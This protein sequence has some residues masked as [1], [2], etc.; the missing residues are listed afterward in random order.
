GELHVSDPQGIQ[1]FKQALQSADIQPGDVVML[2]GT[3]ASKSTDAKCRS[4]IKLA[5]LLEGEYTDSNY[6]ISQWI[7][8]TKLNVWAAKS[9]DFSIQNLAIGLA[10]KLG[11]APWGI[12]VSTWRKAGQGP[13][14]QEVV[15]VGY[16]VCHLP[17]PHSARPTKDRVHVA[18]GMRVSS[19]EDSQVMSKLHWEVQAVAAENVPAAQLRRLIP[20][21]FVKGK[22][23]IIHRDG[24]FTMQELKSLEAYHAEV[25]SSGTSFLLIEIVKFAGG[26]PRLYQGKGQAAQGSAILLSNSSALLVSSRS[27]MGTPNPLMLRMQR[28]LGSGVDTLDNFAWIRS[29]YDLSFMHHG[30]IYCAPRLP[31]T[32]HFADRMAYQLAGGGEEWVQK[33]D[34]KPRSSQQF[35]L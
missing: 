22:I 5:C 26:S 35:W 34:G 7:D 9:L 31:V 27:G 21:D 6:V 15:V 2:F 13:G 1:T 20:T 29:V 16:D 8:L 30:S 18:A 10:G 12:D 4:R 14:G 23:V 24:E 25:A 11:H 3:K 32:T 33:F 17:D 28:R 19:H